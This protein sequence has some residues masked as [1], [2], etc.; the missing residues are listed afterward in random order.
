MVD[1]GGHMNIHLTPTTASGLRAAEQRGRNTLETRRYNVAFE[2]TGPSFTSRVIVSK[3]AS[4][5]ARTTS[6]GCFESLVSVEH[7]GD[8][9]REGGGG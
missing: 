7:A 9:A 2:D 1:T 3:K 8:P 6:Q 5:T 4:S